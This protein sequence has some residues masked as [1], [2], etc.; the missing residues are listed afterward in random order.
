MRLFLPIAVLAAALCVACGSPE[1]SNVKVDSQGRS[2]NQNGAYRTLPPADN[3]G[4]TETPPPEGQAGQPA[5]PAITPAEPITPPP[6]PQSATPAFID[7]KTGQIK[8]LP[9]YPPA[10][11]TNVQMGPIG[12]VSTAMFVFETNEQVEPIAKFYD[13]VAKSQGWK[14]VTRIL[15]TDNYN[16]ELEKG[17]QNE[18]KVQARRDATTGRTTIIV[19]RVEKLPQPKQ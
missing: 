14:V 12:D 5:P 3:G 9:N 6:A 2:Q 16:I 11:R 4:Q 13:Q 10:Q 18:G 1:Y 8:D 17:E 7:L 19:S 15:E